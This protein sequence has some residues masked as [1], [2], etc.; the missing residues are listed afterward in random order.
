MNTIGTSR[1]TT[2]APTSHQPEYPALPSQSDGNIAQYRPMNKPTSTSQTI[3]VRLAHSLG[4]STP[5]RS[6][7]SQSS[8]MR[9]SYAAIS[10]PLVLSTAG[11]E[12]V[13]HASLRQLGVVVVR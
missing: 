7:G 13:L 11:R 1:P 12:P 9:P 2:A 4:V 6:C 10:A 5:G 8:A 3:R